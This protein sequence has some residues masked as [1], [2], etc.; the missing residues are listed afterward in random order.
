MFIFVR[1]KKM[2][3]Q[4]IYELLIK[5]DSGYK[6]TKHEKRELE[7]VNSIEWKNIEMLPKSISLLGSIANLDLSLTNISDISALSGLTALTSL[8]LY[9]TKV[10]DIR[11]LSDLTSLTN[12]YLRYTNVSDIN[13]LSKLTALSILD[14]GETKV[15]DISALNGL[16]ALTSLDL[17]KTK[18]SDISALSR[19]TALT[20]LDLRY[21]SL[22]SI[23]EWL[24]DLELDFL[25]KYNP[26][27]RGIQI[28]GLKLKEQPIEVFTQNREL[29][30]A[31]FRSQ[32]K[33]SAPINECKVIFLGDGGVGK[34][35]IIDRLM[36]NGEHS[37]HFDGESTPG[38]KITS[39]K[40]P[41]GSEEIELHYWDFGGQAIMHSMHRLFLTNRTLYVVVTNARDNKANEQA[42]YWIRN[43]KSFANGAPVLLLIN[44]KDQNP[45]ANINET[46]LRNEYP[47]IKGVSI[48][49]ALKDTPDEFN[50]CIRD[51]ICKIVSEM[52]SVHSL[53]SKSWL[54]LMNDLQ[55]MPSDY[56]DSTVFYK[57]CSD[58]GVD[59]QN[60][61]LDKIISWYQDLGV[62]FYSRKHPVSR[63]YMV[64]KP[65]WLLNA[66]Y[67]L[68]FNGR[69]YATNGIILENDIYSLICER[70]SDDDIK[71]VWPD[72]QYKV[73]E[74]QYIINVLLNFNL[75]YRI[76][77]ERF[78]VPMLC[79]ENEPIVMKRFESE[80][81]IHVSFRYEYLP[82]NVLHRLMVLH[83]FEL[84]TN[85]VW[86]TGA[87]FERKRCGWQALVRSKDNSLDIYARASDQKMHPIN[88][89]LDIIRESVYF[90]NSDFGLEADE[91]IIY[92]K[93]GKKDSFMFKNLE[94]S[95]KVGLNEVY[96]SAFDSLINIDDITGA[97]KSPN[98][99]NGEA[100]YIYECV[101]TACKQIQS[102]KIFWNNPPDHI[103]SENDRNDEMRDLLSNRGLFVRD[104]THAGRGEGG[105]NPGEV[106][107]MIMSSPTDTKTLIE[108]LNL[109][110]V[111]KQRIEK[112]LDKLVNGYNDSG[113]RDLFLVSYVELEK[114]E[115][116]P[117]WKRYKELV[118]VLSAK[119]F[120]VKTQSIPEIDESLSWIKSIR[121]TYDFEGEEMRVYHICVRVAE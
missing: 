73:N 41:I 16:T 100:G 33:A 32:K 92:S 95:K 1:G 102:R 6:P 51:V 75:I 17:S 110:G 53:F 24:L 113:L 83:G 121:I 58:N 107:L 89:Y 54:S 115:F 67:I 99:L 86:K 37:P 64:L 108:A 96:S 61:I 3:D 56:I 34:S 119:D 38:I 46:G 93:D 80:D 5:I 76:D 118:S 98:M 103:V 43:I 4:E 77:N 39:K 84:N 116:P 35:L 63:N 57:K 10:R 66:L 50:K 106:D 52:E 40:Y 72:I 27:K 101:M 19:L 28:Q 85:I 23:P 42:W 14:L 71:K 65:R 74:I 9:G 22:N 87:V 7:S 81:T 47:E 60:D 26:F 79:D 91:F 55:E 69:K 31:Y 104:Q 82:E 88:T 36:K 109:N 117:F 13:A 30:R 62:C 97:I 94:G 20:N 114:R 25:P 2:T 15:S 29:I 59:T 120:S 49:S 18:V 112:H 21:L 68:S 8:I 78:F 12:L 11:A 45:S 70:L 48:V 105:K 111:S 44:Q 90:I